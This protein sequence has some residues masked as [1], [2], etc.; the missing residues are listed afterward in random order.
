MVDD[1]WFAVGAVFVLAVV[2]VLLIALVL[3]MM[4]AHGS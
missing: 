4:P 3:P 2:I 1:F